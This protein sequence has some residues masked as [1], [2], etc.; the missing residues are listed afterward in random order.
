MGEKRTPVPTPDEADSTE[1]TKSGS[2]TD[3]HENSGS[4]IGRKTAI[5]IGASV[6]VGAGAVLANLFRSDLLNLVDPERLKL[7]EEWRIQVFRDNEPYLR[8]L[9]NRANAPDIDSVDFSLVNAEMRREAATSWAFQFMLGADTWLKPSQVTPH[10]EV[11]RYPKDGR[12]EQVMLSVTV[13]N[14]DSVPHSFEINYP[15]CASGDFANPI[16]LGAGL[17]GFEFR[18]ATWEREMFY[19][20]SRVTLEPG[21]AALVVGNCILMYYDSGK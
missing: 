15:A 12:D 7:E 2:P 8:S 4:T 16:S 1:V 21:Q 6:L 20:N 18:T 14:N 10:F 19:T 9:K 3:E 11:M 5:V 17:R 13:Q